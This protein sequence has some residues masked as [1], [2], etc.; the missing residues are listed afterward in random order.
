LSLN[1]NQS[2][3]KRLRITAMATII[4]TLSGTKFSS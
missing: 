1:S 3:K 4:I 2:A